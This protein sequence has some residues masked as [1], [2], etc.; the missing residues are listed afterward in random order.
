[1]N[2][3]DFGSRLRRYR[4]E[5]GLT[6][7]SL[8]ER[9]GIVLRTVA[10]WEAGRHTPGVRELE[11]LVRALGLTPEERQA[12]LVVLPVSK[13][14]R[15]IQA[16]PALSDL[17]PPGIGD[18]IRAL[19]WRRRLSREELAR[20]L[21]VHRTTVRRWEEAQVIPGEEARLRLCDLLGVFPEERAVLL[22]GSPAARMWDGG[23]PLAA[24]RLEAARLERG[25]GREA[26]PLFDLRA[27][28]L[29]GTLW[30][31]AARLPEAR[32][33]LA[34]TYAAH[35]VY[36][37]IRGD[38]DDALDYS[39]RSLNLIKA[40]D[41]LPKATLYHALWASGH[42]LA[43]RAPHRGAQQ[44]LRQAKEWLLKTQSFKTPAFL[45][46]NAAWWALRSG[47]LQEA[48]EYGRAA[49][50]RAEQSGEISIHVRQGLQSFQA[51]L[52]VATG[53]Y[54]AGLEASRQLTRIAYYDPVMSCLFETSVF[55]KMGAR[56][57]ADSSLR[58]AYALI[59]ADQADL[60]CK[61]A[62]AYAAQLERLA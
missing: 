61:E 23:E 8:A 55:L 16:L 41:A 22:S 27:Y 28:L 56:N 52:L 3:E 53:R 13:A 49:N 14:G 7:A 48:Q 6:Q 2:G 35:A 26:A 15:V 1:M 21:G 25:S 5:K 18:L 42:A 58:R 60:Y 24:C 62:D 30:R 46:L 44:S 51:D 17:A 54:E 33:L 47:A 50:A 29:A 12:L 20:S 37:C 34:Q 59:A 31:L 10:Y 36:N 43:H 39:S 4:Q 9:S 19:R 11:G 32:L 38:D 57:D 45:L 40:E